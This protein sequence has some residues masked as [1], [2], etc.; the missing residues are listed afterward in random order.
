MMMMTMGDWRR[1]L[2]TVMMMEE[3]EG[4]RGIAG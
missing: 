2:T 3:D 1:I 4:N